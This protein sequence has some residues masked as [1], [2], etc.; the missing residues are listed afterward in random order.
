MAN[1]QITQLQVADPLTGLEPMPIVQN[2]ITK[3]TLT[4]D[5]AT[6]AAS[7]VP[8]STQIANDTTTNIPVYPLFANI[9]SGLASTIYTSDPNFL[10]TPFEGL[11]QARVLQAD[12]GIVVN[13][14]TVSTSYT[15]PSGSN[16]LSSGPIT[17]AGGATVTVSSGSN[18]N[19]VG[20][21]SLFPWTFSTT[22]P[23]LLVNYNG[24]PVTSI[25]STGAV[26]AA[27][28]VTAFGT[29]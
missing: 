14:A 11:L 23:K 25:D 2:G 12:N 16:G 29:P 28:S 1:K 24:A 20:V 22:G 4:L 10:Y 17:V 15:I 8:P 3:Q 13:S 5:I 19:I 6:L 18:W 21:Y 9:T 26:I 7:L 27:G